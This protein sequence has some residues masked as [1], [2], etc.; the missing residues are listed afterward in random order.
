MIRRPPRSTLF[1]YTTLFRSLKDSLALLA[2]RLGNDRD[3]WRWG[4][5]E[6]IEFAHPLGERGGVLGWYFNRGPYPTE[7]GRHTV[8]NSWFDLGDAPDNSRSRRFR[9]TGSSPTLAIPKARAE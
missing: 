5:M 2:Q 1:P 7:G 9:R 3:K 6:T 8:N 4:A